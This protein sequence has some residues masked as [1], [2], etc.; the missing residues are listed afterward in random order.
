MLSNCEEIGEQG[1]DLVGTGRGIMK[2]IYRYYPTG[3]TENYVEPSAVA[4]IFRHGR[5]TENSRTVVRDLTTV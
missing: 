3:T 5:Q 2:D 4:P 1:Q